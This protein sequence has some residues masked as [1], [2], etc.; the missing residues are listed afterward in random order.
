M[1]KQKS[2]AVSKVRRRKKINRVT[3]R[4]NLQMFL[5]VLPGLFLVIL[6][7]YLPM[8]G[9]VIAF[10]EFNPMKGIWG[11]PWAGFKN[12]E[13]FFAS[14]DA[15]RTISNTFLYAVA[16]LI[17][18]LVTAVG[19]ALML[20]YLKSRRATKFYNTV[21]I[22]PKFMS[23]VI[24]A[25]IVYALL[26][27]SYGLVNQ[28][29]QALGGEGINWYSDPKYWPVILT[30][31]HVWQ[32]VGMNSV[33]Y[34]S[35]LMG[36]DESLLEAAKIDG[37]N[38]RQQIRNVIIPHLVPIMI[39]TTILAI[40]HLFSVNL[41]LF[42]QVPKNQGLLYPTTDVINTYVYRA[43]IDGALEKSA[44]VNLFQSL[45]GLVMVVGTNAIIRKIS[46]E[47]SLF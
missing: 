29:I 23:M 17:I 33:L 36:M 30:L 14:Q 41:D 45:V 4:E 12:F 47:N 8:P 43:L 22:I 37:A 11:S 44:A 18:D 27:P 15:L 16:F 26:S 3:L 1:A 5:M 9:I 40:G 2:A 28:I 20:Y 13:F 34:Y 10:K 25:F 21:V 38:L 24:I 35:T 42:Y 39:I 6:F 7:Y 31:T 46:P 32:M 19:L